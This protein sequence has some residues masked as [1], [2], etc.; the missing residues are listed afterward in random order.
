MKKSKAASIIGLLL[1]LALLVGLFFAIK[2]LS[3]DF[4]TDVKTFYAK[5]DN[6]IITTNQTDMRL[7]EKTITVRNLEGILE[8]NN[9]GFKW[10]IIRNSNSDDF[11]FSIGENVIAFSETQDFSKAFNVEATKDSIKIQ[12]TDLLSVLKAI[13]QADNIELPKEITRSTCYF[14]LRLLT[15]DEKKEI[16]LDF[17][18]LVGNETLTLDVEQVVF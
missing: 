1:L 5:I 9:A 3:N 10:Q 17:S 2:A 18:M 13:Y 6:E 11:I 16:R 15:A 8:Q 7:F 14:T 12:K 4:T